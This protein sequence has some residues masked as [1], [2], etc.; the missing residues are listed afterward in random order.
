MKKFLLSL[1]L[2]L[3]L[4]LPGAAKALYTC[5]FGANY[6]QS[7]VSNY[8]TTWQVKVGE[9]TWSIAN[10]NNNKNGWDYVR[11]GRK[12]IASVAS[13]TTD[14]AIA[15]AINTVEVTIDKSPPSRSLQSSSKLQQPQI[16]PP[17]TRPST[18]RP[19]IS[20]PAKWS[21]LLKPPRQIST[22]V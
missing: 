7:S 17:S 10:F 20:K 14:F 4:G 13:I 22:I 21:S 6:N 18:C 8:T 9:N 2:V 15:E 1:V 16:S 19:I 5:Q 3:C 12:G 11:C